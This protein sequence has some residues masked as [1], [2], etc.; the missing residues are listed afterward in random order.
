MPSH[1]LLEKLINHTSHHLG[2]EGGGVETRV[3]RWRM[4]GDIS[5]VKLSF[6]LVN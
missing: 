1:F 5:L 3:D 2:A 4:E 6:H